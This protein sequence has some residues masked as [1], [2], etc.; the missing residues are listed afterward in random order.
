MIQ[1]PIA[2]FVLL[3]ILASI[4]GS[5]LFAQTDPYSVMNVNKQTGK[6]RVGPDPSDPRTMLN[7]LVN[8]GV[9]EIIGVNEEQ[10]KALAKWNEEGKRVVSELVAS[11]RGSQITREQM[12]EIIASESKLAQ[13]TMDEVLNPDQQ[14]M[15]RKLVYRIEPLLAGWAHAVTYGRLA[16]EIGVSEN[17]IDL[18]QR[19]AQQIEEKLLVKIQVARREAEDAILNELSPEQRTKAIGLI[20]EFVEFEP[21]PIHSQR[22]RAAVSDQIEKKSAMSD[23]VEKP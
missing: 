15:L 19:K 4:A 13:L 22:L 9:K 6:V 1:N 20:G 7:L 8:G 5:H 21:L 2:K 17:Q 11:F 14:A 10:D 12:N 18:L 3:P 16:E 23:T